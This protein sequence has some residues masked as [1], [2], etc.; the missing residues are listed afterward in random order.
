MR[1]QVLYYSAAIALLFSSASV[2]AQMDAKDIMKAG[3]GDANTLM[4]AYMGPMFKSMGAGLNGGW[5]NTAKPHGIGGFDVTICFNVA[6]APTADQSF[7]P[8]ALGFKKLQLSPGQED[9]APTIFGDSKQGPEM[10]LPATITIPDY[11]N[12]GGTKDTT[13]LLSKFNLPQGTGV[14][15]FPMPTAQIALGVGFGTEVA[16][17]YMPTMKAGDFEAGLFGFAVKHDFK[18]WIPGIAMMPFDL[19]AMFG[20]TKTSVT[21]GFGSKG[22]YPT[23]D[24]AQVYRPADLPSFDGQKLS[25]EASGWTLNVLLSKK[26]GPITPYLG[27][28]YQRSSVTFDMKGNYPLEIANDKAATMGDPS[29]GKAT[30]YASFSDPIHLTG[31]L[32][33]FRTTVG[34]RLKLLLLTIHADYTLAEYKM[35]TAGVGLNLQSIVPF[36]L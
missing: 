12:P 23:A 10:Y 2:K 34:L 18:Q 11:A 31:N 9:K 29:F 19:S 4:Q 17:R 26:L 20:Y 22:L 7:T 28:G 25:F 24:T 35:F 16:V 27:L 33:G 8:S 15:Y 14:P 13:V 21:L 5:F 32:S 6:Q 3:M 30:R 1:K 36:K